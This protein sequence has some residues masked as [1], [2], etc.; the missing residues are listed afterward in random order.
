MEEGRQGYEPVN[1]G[2][3]RYRAE[4]IWMATFPIVIAIIA[5]V[6]T[7]VTLSL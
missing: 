6:A 5:V 4:A 2:K 3:N 1:H 7:M